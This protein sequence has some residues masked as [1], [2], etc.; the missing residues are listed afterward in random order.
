M[1][2]VERYENA[3]L[4]GGTYCLMVRIDFVEMVIFK[5]WLEGG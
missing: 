4:E 1:G 2:Q 5:Q 3:H